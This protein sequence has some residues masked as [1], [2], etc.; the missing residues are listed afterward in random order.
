[1]QS[2]HYSLLSCRCSTEKLLGLG[3]GGGL[4]SS[5]GLRGP[6]LAGGVQGLC[7]LQVQPITVGAVAALSLQGLCMQSPTPLTL[8]QGPTVAPHH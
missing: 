4:G 2:L 6:Y 5:M 3:R 7:V 8:H 1:M